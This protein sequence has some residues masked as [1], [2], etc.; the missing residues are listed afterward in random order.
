MRVGPLIPVTDLV[1]ARAFY[2][3]QLG[4]RGSATPGGWQVEYDDGTVL[5]LLELSEGPGTASWPLASFRVAD[6]STRTREL[7]GLG[8]RFL[9]DVPFELDED[10]V[11]A[12]ENMAVSWLTDPDGNVLTLFRVTTGS[13]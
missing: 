4:G 9:D 3:D 5:Y 7:I 1:R 13:P 2:E 6:V 8:V 12:D 11:H 10:G